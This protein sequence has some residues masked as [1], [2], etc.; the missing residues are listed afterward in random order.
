MEIRINMKLHQPTALEDLVATLA[1]AEDTKII[2]GGTA[3]VLMMQ[4]GLVFP[5]QLVSTQRIA[6]LHGVVVHNDRITIGATTTLREVAK[7]PSIQHA[8]PALA[9]ACEVV[10][11]VRIRNVATLGGNLAEADYASD[12]PA[13]LV[14]LGATV[15]ILGPAGTRTSSVEDLLT[16]FYSTS[17]ESAEVITAIEIPTS[18]PPLRQV[19]LKYRS[20]SSEDRPCVG[21]AACLR[22][23]GDGTTVEELRVAV[24][25][26]AATPQRFPELEEI[27]LGGSLDATT[28]AGIADGYAEAIEALDDLRGSEWYRRQMT[29]VFVARA[30]TALTSEGEVA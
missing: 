6:A 27:A 21:V 28:I 13:T 17:L 7:D 2:S 8:L 18:D 19:Y 15:E 16:G 29:R 5:E 1:D 20:R 9:H 3:L 25:A 24:G 12:P 14:A 11:N 4:Q 30:L 10:G 22:L 26:A 23:A